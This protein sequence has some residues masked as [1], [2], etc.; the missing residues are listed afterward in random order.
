MV[1]E[2]W[3]IL[4]NFNTQSM[5]FASWI[6]CMWHFQHK[7]SVLL[8]V[9]LLCLKTWN[10]EFTQLLGNIC[11]HSLKDPFAIS[12]HLCVRAHVYP[13]SVCVCVCACIWMYVISCCGSCS[14]WMFDVTSS[15]RRESRVP[16]SRGCALTYRGEGG[17]GEGDSLMFVLSIP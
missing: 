4:I 17:S 6:G 5:P 10:I 8:R 12:F 14:L 1:F 13:S 16:R 2:I 9:F 7:K 11:A 3:L 15:V